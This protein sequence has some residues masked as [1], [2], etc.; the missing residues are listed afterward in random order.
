MRSTIPADARGAFH[1]PPACHPIG[2]SGAS[3]GRCPFCPST[4]TPR[5]SPPNWHRVSDTQCQNNPSPPAALLLSS[6][7]H[8]LKIRAQWSDLV[9]RFLR[10][11][12]RQ[13]SHPTPSRHFAK[14]LETRSPPPATHFTCRPR[15]T[16]PPK[17]ARGVRHP[18]PKQLIP[19]RRNNHA[20]CRRKSR[21]APCCRPLPHYNIHTTIPLRP[22]Q[23]LVYPLSVKGI[24]TTRQRSKRSQRDY[25][26]SRKKLIIRN[27]YMHSKE[28][29]SFIPRSSGIR[30][31]P[32]LIPSLIA[33]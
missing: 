21:R 11:H 27:K 9:S 20:A 5:L 30:R 32:H 26:C 8:R 14:C 18:A 4:A 10:H 24:R 7:F 6:A 28:T 1:L 22:I 19:A 12:I 13:P 3:P 25:S 16:S 23:P 33:N 17:L 29:K 15:Q 31:T 2:G